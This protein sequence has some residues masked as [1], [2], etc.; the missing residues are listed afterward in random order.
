MEEKDAKQNTPKKK[1]LIKRLFKILTWT[2][3]GIVL[4]IALILGCV[5]WILT[6]DRLTPIVEQYANEYVDAR[7]DVGRVELTFWGTFPQLRVDVDSLS[8]VSDGLTALTPE[9]RMALPENADTV[10]YIGH[11][12]GGVN[13]M[14]LMTGKID[15]YD[16]EIRKPMVNIVQYN[17]SINN[18]SIISPS[19]ETADTTESE[20]SI[21]DLAID[22]FTIADALPIRY[23][24]HS[25]NID[26]GITLGVTYLDGNEAPQYTL[27]VNGD[28]QALLP[29]TII[30]RN[31]PIGI[32]GKIDWSPATPYQ[33][34]LSDF[35]IDIA[36]LH[37][38]L[39]TSLDFSSELTVNSFSMFIDRLP[40]A[41]AISHMPEDIRSSLK[42][43]NTDIT[44]SAGATLAEPYVISD[45]S[46]PMIDATLDINKGYLRF[47]KHHK[48]LTI[49]SA[50]T[51]NI[52]GKNLDASVVTVKSLSV[53]GVSINA[54]FNGTFRSLLSD[55]KVVAH[56]D[57]KLNFN[58]FPPILLNKIPGKITGSLT[59][60]TDINLRQS[61]LSKT[62]F[63]KAKLSGSA[64]LHNFTFNDSN[65]SF[66]TRATTFRFGSS[67]SF[68]R[69]EHRVDS[70]LTAS[71]KIDTA[72]VDYIG[73]RINIS[74]LRAGIGCANIASS[75]DS[76]QVNPIS[77]RIKARR[78]SA[79]T[80]DS[81]RLRLRDI[82]CRASLRRFNNEAKV[83]QLSLIID[84]KRMNYG[85]NL[86][87]LN[88]REGK[89]DVTAHLR[90]R[91]GMSARMKARY[92]SIAM[93]H[94]ELPQD[95]IFK[96]ARQSNR[97][98][99]RPVKISDEEVMDFA[100]D[101]STKDLLRRW[102]VKGTITAKR[103]RL[104]TPYFPLRNRLSDID[105]YFNSDSL[106]L[107]DIKYNVGHSDM[108]VNGSIRNI[109]R[110]LTSRRGS[111]LTIR[112][113]VNSDTIDVNQIAEATFAGAA[114]AERM[115]TQNISL[116]H[117]EN[118]D[119]LEN[120]LEEIQAP[121]SAMAA[122][123]IPKNIDASIFVRAENVLYSD[124]VLKQFRGNVL[125][126]EGAVNMRR[127]SAATDMGNLKMSALYSAPNKKE[128][129]FGF[130]LE[131]KDLQLDKVIKMIPAIDSI[132][133]MLNEFE[134]IID[135]DIAAT[136]DID[137][138]MN[139]VMP[140]LSA[141][142]KLHGD[143]LVLL[144]ADT[145]KSLSKWLLFK[146]KKRNMIDKMTVEAVIDNSQ[147]ELFPF[148][149]DIDRY[150]L[151]IMGSN[152][153]AMNYKYHISVL[154]SPLPFKFGINVSGD[155]DDMKIRIGK[156][157]FKE[158]M[159]TERVAIVD[160]TRINLLNQIENVFRR[161]VET[162]RLSKLKVD[163]SQIATDTAGEA[164]SDTISHADSLVLIKEGLLE[165]PPEPQ[166]SLPEQN[167]N[168]KKKNK[169]KTK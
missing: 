3:I 61:H 98:S 169:K 59:A 73:T 160:T 132:M 70:L 123:I 85:D 127:L 52:N 4:L 106:M 154:K 75:L 32:N 122:L 91:K 108:V 63:H 133:P 137:S 86:N 103:G 67:D 16:V 130:G 152:D 8:I 135:A 11:F 146:N 119:S 49:S 138:A 131:I 31:I 97:R 116:A 43:I 54:D 157:K 65:T 129:R 78:I 66:Y 104:F 115:A 37:S 87:R 71:V 139:F 136:T 5:V 29:P 110:A 118:E 95:S 80:T 126:R 112:F 144:D 41:A 77:A 94:P 35:N 34:A 105:I 143:S 107:N 102:D 44:V 9:Q 89:I 99:R 159:V 165:A 40:I 12:H 57:G 166:D 19:A 162:S 101:N 151:G 145:F 58:N 164:S 81:T 153:M 13:L 82:T 18:F 142:I 39:S 96:L 55:P 121:D 30:E 14:S 33:L 10:L 74:D 134:G 72:F 38:T 2:I 148:M 114:F 36:E 125:M 51:A 62:H 155:I 147:L 27:N 22:R 69:G 42:M 20:L 17:D 68:T 6:P 161:G 24:S 76:T 79:N 46:L 117:I 84:A 140:S 15:V 124:M 92:D 28:A 141:A 26:A 45:T 120:T 48:P 47:G 1:S 7:V 100:L 111:P 56:F 21:P 50:I 168:G 149:F 88:L 23:F 158:K 90:K 113:R 128:M 25:N 53:D 83:P 93:L 163:R 167:K 60:K 64:T 156:A 150:R 109:R